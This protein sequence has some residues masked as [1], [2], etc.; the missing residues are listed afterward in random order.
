MVCW[1]IAEHNC[2]NADARRFYV[3]WSRKYLS[4]T[5]LERILLLDISHVFRNKKALPKAE[6]DASTEQ[7]QSPTTVW[8]LNI[9]YLK[10]KANE[11]T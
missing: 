7:F 10:L 9:Y 6:L 8:K 11:V 1:G 3:E 2:T 5:S 4:A